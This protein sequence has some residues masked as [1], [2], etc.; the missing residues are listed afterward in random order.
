MLEEIKN[1]IQKEIKGVEWEKVQSCLG[2]E[3][4]PPQ[5]IN[6]VDSLN[7]GSKRE[8]DKLIKHFKFYSVNL[9]FCK[10]TKEI[11]EYGLPKN[12]YTTLSNYN[13]NFNLGVHSD[14]K[15]I[16]EN[17]SESFKVLKPTIRVSQFKDSQE[18]NTVVIEI[19]IEA[20]IHSKE[21]LIYTI[22][23]FFK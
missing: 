17:L 15:S 6:I 20:L 14:I 18:E 19:K 7:I 8:N 12:K 10:E 21:R 4:V 11:N 23:I 2:A 9:K 13:D 16:F 5:I 3:A 22:T 1:T